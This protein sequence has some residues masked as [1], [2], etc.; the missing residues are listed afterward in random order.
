MPDLPQPD[1]ERLASHIEEFGRRIKLS[2]TPEELELPL[3]RTG[4]GVLRLSYG[5]FCHT[6]P[7]SA[8]QDMRASRQMARACVASR[9]RCRLR[10]RATAPCAARLCRRG[11]R[12]GVCGSRCQ[13]QIVLV[14]GI[15][16]E[17]VTALASVRGALGHLHVSPNEHLYEMCVSPVWG[18]PSQHTRPRLP[19]PSPA[20]S[21]ATTARGSGRNAW[22]ARPSV[23]LWA[24]VDTGWRKTPILVAELSFG[25]KQA[26]RPPLCCFPATM[27]PGTMVSWIMAAPM[28]RCWRSHGLLAERRGLWRRGLRLCFWSGHSHGRYSGSAWYAD[29]YWDELD[30]RCVAHVNVDFDGRRGGER[31][32]QLGRHRRTEIRCGRSG[33]GG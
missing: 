18:S 22:R 27:T 7:I 20:R 4:D 9:I 28:P 14:D 6:T 31:A 11:R 24:D 25:R 10:R 1:R 19:T 30:R 23:S 21:R 32:H 13:R 15:A 16:T 5:N 33:R 17:E 2:G 29:E 3:S 26:S 8:C 12:G